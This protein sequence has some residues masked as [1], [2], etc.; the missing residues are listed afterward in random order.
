ML[1]WL[2]GVFNRLEDGLL[3]MLVLSMVVLSGSQLVLRNLDMSGMVWSDTAL[4]VNVLWLAMFGA[5]R[6]SR[7]Q[8]HISIDVVT[9]YLSPGWH[10]IMHFGVSFCCAMICILAAWYSFRFVMIERE[11]SIPAFLNVPVWFCE[12]VIPFAFAVIAW[13]FLQ[14]SLTLPE[15]H[16]DRT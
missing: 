6:A 14:Y 9:R 13:R 16:A 11:D 5:M 8:Q 7:M 15:T 12:A 2:G 1:R 4:R 10:K 3:F